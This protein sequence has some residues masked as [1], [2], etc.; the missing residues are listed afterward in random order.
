ML[1]GKQGTSDF[2]RRDEGSSCGWRKGVV[3]SPC[4]CPALGVGGL[5]KFVLL[6]RLPER[7]AL[8]GRRVGSG[9]SYI[10]DGGGERGLCLCLAATFLSDS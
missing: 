10:A 7:R 3:S 1:L 6:L 8:R 2:E 4:S 9:S 5:V